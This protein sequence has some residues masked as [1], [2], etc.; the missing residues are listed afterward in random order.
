M[1]GQWSRA[2]GAGRQCAP[3]A[4]DRRFWAPLNFTVRGPFVTPHQ[5]V[6]LALRL[7]AIWMGIQALGYVPWFFQVRGSQSPDY[8]YVT[9]MFALNLVIILALW[10]FPRMIAWKL[11][12]SDDTRSQPPATAD[13][14]LAMGCTLIG[15]WTLTTTIPRLVEYSYLVKATDDRWGLAPE[16]LSQLVKLAIAVWLVLG[17]KGVGRIFRWAQY[18]GIRKDL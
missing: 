6:A 15:L 4:S 5:I 13:T 10:F 7:F 9:F 8:V 2:A 14:W 11:V 16:V 12:P 3:A 17:G 1:N 18:A